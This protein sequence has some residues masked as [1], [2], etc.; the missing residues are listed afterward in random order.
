MG[1]NSDD[2]AGTC[3]RTQD[4]ADPGGR[5]RRSLQARRLRGRE[6]RGPH[7]QAHGHGR[8]V[9]P[10]GRIPD[11]ACGVP[12]RH[13]QPEQL[14]RAHAARLPPKPRGAAAPHQVLPGG[15]QHPRLACA[16][17]GTRQ[18]PVQHP[19]GDPVGSHERLQP[20][21]HRLLGSGVRPRAQPQLRGHLLDHRPGPR[22]GRARLHLHGRRTA[23]AQGRPHPHLREVPRLRFSLLHQRHPHRRGLLP[24]DDPCCQLRARDQRRGQR[25]HH[26]RTPRRGHLRQDRARDGPAARA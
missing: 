23:G 11:A 15:R 9:R 5:A 19:V 10:C 3:E 2:T 20:A 26:G 7:P 22:A 4:V 6:P 13:R 24:G 25:A 8:S 14:V 17:G 16:G 21:L 12:P 1:I 18:A